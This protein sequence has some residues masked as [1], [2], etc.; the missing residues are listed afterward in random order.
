MK[1]SVIV[2]VYNV[3]SYIKQCVE[4]ILNQSFNEFELILV[5]DGSGDNSGI[6]C[7]E[8][9]QTDD[10]I[11][12]V[13]KENGGVS[14]ARNAGLD[15]AKGE[16]I[17]FV[18]S[19]DCI[20]S[21]MLEVLY[22]NMMKYDT[23]ISGIEYAEFSKSLPAIITNSR[24]KYKKNDLM[25]FIMQKNR[26]YCVVRYLYKTSILSNQRFDCD[27]K[28][29][30]DQMFVFDYVSKCKTLVMSNYNGYFYRRNINSLSNGQLK[31]SCKDE[32]DNR[33]KMID[34]LDKKTKKYGQAHYW[35]G[36]IAYWV[37]AA[38]YGEAEDC[39]FEKV[40]TAKIRKNT[41]KILSSFHIE[42]RYK[43]ICFLMFFGVNNAK[44]IT[45]KLLANRW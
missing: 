7:D 41:F 36:V 29:G 43:A 18:D 39:N 20:A 6:I 38:I 3:E 25:K 10:R 15:I 4:S 33:L 26:L 11:V 24:I 30:E 14:S 5:D 8:L 21:D 28:L 19:D 13:H 37:R 12:C 22:G 40:F 27:I 16:Y 42:F 17:A 32:L 34:I 2:P 31:K 9:A 35:K 23:D 45:K 1:V 44:K